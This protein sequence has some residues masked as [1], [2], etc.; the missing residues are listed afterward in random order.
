M[1]ESIINS[2]KLIDLRNEFENNNIKALLN[3][4]EKNFNTAKNYRK[5]VKLVIDEKVELSSWPL[6][7]SRYF[8]YD[9]K[10]I[11]RAWVKIL[12][13]ILKYGSLK[14]SECEEPQKD[15]FLS[16]LIKENLRIMLMKLLIKK[17]PFGVEYIWRKNF[18]I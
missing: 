17:K 16:L 15:Y 5:K 14:L 12:D 11:F 2:V 9:D 8:I 4:I 18:Q 10:S 1:I 3:V 6:T 13:L 7:L